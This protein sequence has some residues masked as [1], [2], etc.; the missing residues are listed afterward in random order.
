[1]ALTSKHPMIRWAVPTLAVAAIGA[2]SLAPKAIAEPTLPPMTAEQLLVAVQDPTV[3]DFSGTIETNSDLGLPA[4]PGDGSDFAALVSGTNTVRVWHAGKDKSRV[5][6]LADGAETSVIRN[7]QDV[8]QWSSKERTAKHAVLT[9]HDG[10]QVRS[11]RPKPAEGHGVEVP[12]TP[13]EAAQQVLA[14]IEPTTTVTVDRTTRVAGRSAYELILDP[15][16]SETLVAKVAIAVDAETKAPLRVEVWGV[17]AD[18]P[19]MQVGFTQID[20]RTP[21]E[22][23]FRFAPPAGVTVEQV[24]KGDK[25]TSHAEGDKPKPPEPVVVGEGW[26]KVTIV[27]APEHTGDA[28]AAKSATGTGAEPAEGRGTE[29]AA[30]FQAMIDQL[31]TVQGPWGSGKV[32]T[33]SLFTVVLTDDGRVAV[34]MVPTSRVVAAIPQ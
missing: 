28:R 2:V 1:M 3:E 8:W 6:L 32:L 22:S 13:A 16:S 10:Q 9:D 5:S 14:A 21:S 26:D 20:F 33:S 4:L 30:E 7:G 24:D 29:Q 34:G 27:A 12:S 31:P 23:V 11:A 17:G 18:K 25:A 15:K 19:A